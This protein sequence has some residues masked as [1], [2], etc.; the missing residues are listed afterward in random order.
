MGSLIFDRLE[1]FAEKVCLI[2]PQAAA[3][4]YADVVGHADALAAAIVPRSLAVVA[5]SNSFES[6][7]GYIGLMRAGAAVLLV[8]HTVKPT[9]FADVLERYKP[10]YLLAPRDLDCSA[11]AA[12]V[13]APGDDYRLLETT[14]EIDYDLHPELAVL[15]ATS[16]STG[17]P[18]FVRL[19]YANIDANAEAIAE[20]LGISA[21]DRPITTMPMSYSYGLSILHSHLLRGASVIVNEEPLVGAGFWRAFE[22]HRATTFGGVPFIY[23]ILKKLKFAEMELPNLAYLTQAGGK[24]SLELTEEF[25][26]VCAAK[27]IDFVVMYGQTEAAP[28]M[29]ALPPGAA[30]DKL[31]SV[32][33]PIPG[34]RF[35][36]VDESGSAIDA[37]DTPGSLMYEG[38]N[39]SLGY[40]ETRFDLA[41][42]DDNRGILDTGDIAVFDADGYYY[43]VGRKKRFLKVYGNRISL[44]DVERILTEHGYD[45]ACAGTDDDLRIFVTGDFVEREVMDFVLDRV[46]I[47]QSGVSIVPL[48]EIPRNDAGKVLYS[49]LDGIGE[50]LNGN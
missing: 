10:R 16:G 27:D 45:T 44:D 26:D 11:F 4:S 5:A 41:R 25:T 35:W 32:G 20:S 8:P 38:P 23:E 42:G 43:I 34:G 24:L 29:S 46:S 9:H 17:A 13:P 30:R 19:S 22:Q 49:V 14:Y 12:E 36:L 3:Y 21:D 33:K 50:G 18:A 40:A 48:A 37:A 7:A 31:G 1:A 28:R 6:V 47:N 15:L 39:V 2:D